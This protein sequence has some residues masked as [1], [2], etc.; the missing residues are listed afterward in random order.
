MKLRN[1]KT[2]VSDET[3]QTTSMSRTT[4]RRKSPRFSEKSSPH[5]QVRRST[6]L[7]SKKL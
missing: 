2:Y 7:R 1:G 4:T 3:H 5:P 6:R